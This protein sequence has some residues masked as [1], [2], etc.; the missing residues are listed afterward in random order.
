MGREFRSMANA[1]ERRLQ[2]LIKKNA[3]KVEAARAK[4]QPSTFD[5]TIERKPDDDPELRRFFQDMKKREF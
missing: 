4:K 1:E 3:A 5:H 2:A